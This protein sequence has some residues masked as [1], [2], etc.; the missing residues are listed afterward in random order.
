MGEGFF[1][2]YLYVP[3]AEATYV[4]LVTPWGSVHMDKGF[5]DNRRLRWT[6][7]WSKGENSYYYA[8]QH[9]EAKDDDESVRK[10]VVSSYGWSDSKRTVSIYLTDN[11][12][13]NMK[14]EQLVL[15]WTKTSLSMDLLNAPGG[16]QAKSLH[17][18]PWKSL[19][20]AAKNMEDHIEYDESL[21]D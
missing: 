4:K 7:A 17:E 14:D 19:N 2:P 5:L 20:G 16:D 1:V 9:R 10:S 6:R 8:H 21:Y 11:L 15:K 3:S 18:P 13:K 12:V